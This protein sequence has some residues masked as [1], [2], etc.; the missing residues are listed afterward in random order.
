MLIT[1]SDDG[2]F[3]LRQTSLISFL[4]VTAPSRLCV[5]FQL[6]LLDFVGNPISRQQTRSFKTR[7]QRS[8][9][10]L[11]RLRVGRSFDAVTAL[12]S[13]RLTDKRKLIEQPLAQAKTVRVS[14]VADPTYDSLPDLRPVQFTALEFQLHFS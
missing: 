6:N 10:V 5:K 7:E 13:R 14:N 11:P 4:C 3:G 8:C 12:P 1:R 9:Y 2:Y